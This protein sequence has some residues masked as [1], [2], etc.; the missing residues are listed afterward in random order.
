MKKKIMICAFTVLILAVSGAQAALTVDIYSG[1]GT[2]DGGAPYS[3]LVGSFQS[4]DIMFATNT[5]YRW[6]PFGLGDFGAEI[7]G[8]LAVEPL[9]A[10]KPF[11]LF[12]LN[13]DGGSMLY[14]DNVL[15]VDNGGPHGPTTVIAGT[16][17]TAGTHS[18]RVEFYEDFGGPS[19][20][21]LILPDGVTYTDCQTIPAPGAM[22]LGSIGAGL[23]GW[24]RRRRAL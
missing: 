17:L 9:A 6:D 21:D 12:W 11:L 22:L 13:S 14:I 15:V 24:L 10:G 18:F 23:V 16:A 3:G 8:C 5:G 2:T 1:H 7:T 20:V 4:P 19:G